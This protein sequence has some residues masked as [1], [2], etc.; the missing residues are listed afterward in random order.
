[1]LQLSKQVTGMLKYFSIHGHI[2][3][4]RLVEP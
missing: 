3:I 1:M 4:V 2:T